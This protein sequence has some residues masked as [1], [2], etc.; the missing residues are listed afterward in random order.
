[1]QVPIVHTAN[2]QAYNGQEA[3][4]RA[5]GIRIYGPGANTAQDLEPE[6]VA[7]SADSST[8]WATLQENNALAKIDIATATITDILPLGF[9]DHAVDGN[10]MDTSDDDQVIEIS[11]WPGVRGLFLPDAMA[12]YDVEG[13]TYLVTANEGD[14]RAWGED[15]D[16][17]WAGDVDQGFVEEF[18]V[19][20]LAHVDGFSRRV[21]DDLP[22]QL[23]ALA[24]GALL[25]PEIF[26]YCGAE[27]PAGIA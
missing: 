26:G 7:I 21:G 14:A 11:A 23:A 1:L 13:S 25:N 24:A 17:Y 2:F 18:R 22:P 4:L 16:A 10:G 8:A 15:N 12:S 27:T 19:K 20:H 9:K 6:Y 5:V 3:E